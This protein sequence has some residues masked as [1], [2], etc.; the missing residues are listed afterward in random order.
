MD[1]FH[2]C[3]QKEAYTDAVKRR[4]QDRIQSTKKNIVPKPFLPSDKT[5]FPSGVG[6]YYGT[7][8]LNG[9]QSHKYFA[10]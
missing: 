6:S 8:G 4:R 1:L 10:G 7:F 9:Q 3:P 5:K 2:Y